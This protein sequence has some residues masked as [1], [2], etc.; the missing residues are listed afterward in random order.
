MNHAKV[1]LHLVLVVMVFV[2]HLRNATKD[3]A[4]HLDHAQMV[5]VSA[6]SMMYA[7]IVNIVMVNVMQIHLIV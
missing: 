6:V 4:L 1:N 3:V 2:I 5:L 7:V